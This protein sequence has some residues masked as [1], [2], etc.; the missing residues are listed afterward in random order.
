LLYQRGRPP[1]A[2]YIFKHAL[3]QDAAYQSLLRRTRQQY[4]QR[5][6]ELMEAQFPAL[7]TIEPEVVAHHYTEADCPE[8]AVHYWHQ[9][10]ERARQGS[11]HVEAIAHLNKALEL[12][13]TL[14]ETA[15]RTQQE[16]VVHLALALVEELAHAF[17]LAVALDYAAIFHQFRRE[18]HLASQRAEAAMAICAEQK[19][20]YYLGWAM[21]I[22]GW[23]LAEQ[24]DIETGI[25][26]IHR[27]LDTLR[28]T[29]AKRSLPYYLA[30]LA[31]V[32]GKSGQAEEGLRVLDE[33]F[34]EA[35]NIGEP[36]WEAELHRLRGELILR[37]EGSIGNAAVTPEACFQKALAVARRQ[38]SKSLEL[39][40]AVSLSRLWQSQG[41]RQDASDLLAPIYDW[42][43]EGFDT[44]DLKDAKALL[45]ELV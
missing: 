1:R 15:D 26:Q 41:K 34:A 21:I 6:A 30:L 11:A 42:F 35:Q 16:L 13:I 5:V 45:D 4:H 7:V 27:G 17:T 33:A 29:G 2:R 36:W 19:F 23:A 38:Q 31:E 20:A 14:P 9:A 43:T 40:A 10:C 24:G 32:Y 18:A 12:L 28:D 25:T 44:A 37:S 22:K 39:R 8:Q 3:L